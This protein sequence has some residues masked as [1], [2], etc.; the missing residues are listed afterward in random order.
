MNKMLL[1]SVLALLLS[2]CASTEQ[3]VYQEP[4]FNYIA[5]HVRVVGKTSNYVIYEY[6]N[7][8]VDEVAPVAAIWCND[9]GGRQ[10]ALYDISLRPD[11]RRRA[12]FVCK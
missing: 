8:R 5:S 4:E 6:S 2:A 12:T 9:H 1:G 7:I 11:H 3:P 10:A